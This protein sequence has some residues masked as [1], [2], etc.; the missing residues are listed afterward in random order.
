M[1]INVRIFNP[2][3]FPVLLEYD[4]ICGIFVEQERVAPDRLARLA[5]SAH[6]AGKSLYVSL[7]YIWNA[8]VEKTLGRQISAIIGAGVDGYLIRNIDELGLLS[9]R[10][11]PGKKILD[12]GL[13]TWN[14]LAAKELSL[15]GADVFTAPYELTEKELDERSLSKTELIIYGSYPL[16][17]SSNCL[18]LTGGKCVREKDP[19][20]T[21]RL[22]DRKN[23]TFNAVNCCK[24]CYNIIFNSVPVW[25]LD[26]PGIKKAESLGFSFTTESRLEIRNI[27]SS[28]FSGDTAPKRPI[29]RGHYKKG[30]E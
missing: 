16:M 24:Y 29:T 12:A 25:L 3:H 27:L 28:F 22:K 15:L 20:G 7:P 5:E 23:V 4:R 13:Y 2:D 14:S 21:Y 8:E 26:E 11:A 10:N 1:D 9:D 18:R 30:T 19:Y 17:V 6:E